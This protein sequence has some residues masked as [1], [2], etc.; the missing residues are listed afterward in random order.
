MI[1]LVRNFH[2]VQDDVGSPV[3]E[4]VETFLLILLTL[5]RKK[6]P[7][8]SYEP[9]LMQRIQVP[10][11]EKVI[12][13]HR[14]LKNVPIFKNKCLAITNFFQDVDDINSN[15]DFKRRA[16]SAGFS[17]VALIR[18]NNVYTWGNSAQGCLGEFLTFFYQLPMKF[19]V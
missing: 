7:K 15:A 18:N 5:I 1:R 6:T 9:K 8:L 12:S 17:H 10:N 19:R 3:E 16:L 14:Y 4:L 11:A 2:F 13:F